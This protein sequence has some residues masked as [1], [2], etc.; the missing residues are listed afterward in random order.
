M[1]FIDGEVRDLATGMLGICDARGPVALAGVMGSSHTEVSD[2][3]RTILLESAAFNNVSI[4]RTSRDLSLRSEASSRFEKGLSPELA[5][6]AA[7][8]AMQLLVQLTGGKAAKGFVDAYPGR[9]TRLPIVLTPQRMEQVLG[10]TLP[11]AET[12]RLLASLGFSTVPQGSSLAVAAPYWRTDVTMEDDL[13]EEVARI[14]GY[15]WIPTR[16]QAG[17]L[18][19]FDPQPLYTLKSTVRDTLTAAGLDE[20]VSYPLTSRDVREK[21]LAEVRGEPLRPQKPLSSEL[22]EMRVTLRGNLLRALAANQRNQEGGVRLFEAGKV[23]LPRPEDLPEERENVALVLSGR[24]LEQSWG[25]PADEQLDFFDAKG[26]LEQLFWDLGVRAEYRPATHPFFRP[27]RC[28]EVVVVGKPAGL[29]GEVHPD[30]A[31]AFDLLPRPVAYAE[32]DLE[33]LLPLLP[34]KAHLF[35]PF[36]RFPGVIRDMALVLDAAV[37]A[38]RVRDLIAVTPL[39]HRVDLFDVYVGDKVPAGKKSLAYRVVYQA[40][41]RTLTSE[42]AQRAQD[43]LLERL[44]RELGAELRG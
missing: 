13:I 33:T 12:S 18:P 17:R 11:Q 22:E 7:R 40:P 10:A 25:S 41:D 9:K 34:D 8:R 5:E 26:V 43:R 20:T 42:E 24:R 37:P 39:V 44:K 2:T 19:L 6:H 29:I 38:G 30:A 31:H 15:D 35:R 4:R 14:R 27:G 16:V 36:A 28:A 32:I 1:P 23:Y 3:T 21:T